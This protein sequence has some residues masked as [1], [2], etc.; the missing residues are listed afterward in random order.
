VQSIFQKILNVW[1]RRTWGG[2]QEQL[3]D[4]RVLEKADLGGARVTS[5]FQV[6]VRVFI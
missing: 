1:P 4:D 2:V 3:R 5:S 6:Q